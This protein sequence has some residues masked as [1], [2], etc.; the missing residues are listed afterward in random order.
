MPD[1]HIV[2]DT[3][4]RGDWAIKRDGRKV[5]DAFTQQ[6]AINAV[7][8]KIGNVGDNVYVH[9]MDNRIRDEFTLVK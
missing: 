7:R 9:G 6:T 2:H 5:H 3:S 4:G 8:N 1:Y